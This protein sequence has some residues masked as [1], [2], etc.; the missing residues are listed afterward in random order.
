MFLAVLQNVVRRLK[1]AAP[2]PNLM[3]EVADTDFS[4]ISYL[5][6]FGGFGS[7]K[8]LG[9]IQY[10]LAH[11]CD[12]LVR[13]DLNGPRDYLGLLMVGVDQANLDGN[14]WELAYRITDPGI[15]SALQ[16]LQPSCPSTMDHCCLGLRD[17]LHPNKAPGD[18]GGTKGLSRTC[19]CPCPTYKSQEEEWSICQ[20]E[21]SCWFVRG[22]S[23]A[24]TDGLL[25]DFG[26]G[27][28]D[29][30]SPFFECNEVVDDGSHSCD[31]LEYEVG[32]S[33]EQLL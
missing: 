22:S 14:G 8:E 17:G 13:S 15:R 33:E 9:L 6:Q 25:Q 1:P 4:M 10:A 20:G 5:E 23:S 30:H 2:R 28:P 7:Y 31:S 18:D 26:G 29:G 21:G 19:Y 3:E 32:V 11:I 24:V 27:P 12:V 16:E